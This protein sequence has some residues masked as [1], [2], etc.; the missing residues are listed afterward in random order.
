[1]IA[2]IETRRPPQEEQTVPLCLYHTAK[3]ATPKLGLID[4]D[5]VIDVAASGG[6]Q[7]LAQALQLSAAELRTQLEAARSRGGQASMLATFEL[8]AP[9]DEQEVWASGVTYLRSRDAR[10]EEST[11][12]NVYDIVYEAERPELFYKA[13]KS[14]VSG[15]GDEIGIRG[16]STWDVPEPELALVINREGEIV[17]YTIGNDVSSRSIEGENPLYLPQAKVYSK[18]AAVGPHVALAWELADVS[19]LTIRLVINRDGKVFFDG[20]TATSQI[21]RRLD[22]LVTYLRRDNEF[23]AGVILMT[24]TGVIPPSEFTLENGDV[25]EISIDGIG[26]LQN[27]VVRLAN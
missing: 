5:Q 17:G 11:Q 2:T 27:P 3:G 16:D 13:T 4:G 18:C 21:H 26:T 22:E 6:P 14:R 10:M 1:M 24:G 19:N 25:V 9:I 8:A 7:S 12:K 23:P 15:P 20:S